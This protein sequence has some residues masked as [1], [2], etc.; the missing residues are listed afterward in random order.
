MCF[1][2]EASFTAAAVLGA[3]GLFTMSR[4]TVYLLLLASV[5]FFFALQQ[6]AEGIVWVAINNGWYPNE[7]SL[8]AQNI[9]LMFAVI[10]WPIWIPFALY[11]AE[12]VEWRRYLLAGF[13]AVGVLHAIYNIMIAQSSGEPFRATVVG[14]SLQDSGQVISPHAYLAEKLIYLMLIIIPCFISSLRSMWLF[15]ILVT[16]AYVGAEYIYR[17]NFASVWC[18]FAGLVSLFLY[19]V[20]M[21]NATEKKRHR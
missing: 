4:S 7:S 8:A 21:D 3:M 1:S 14:H 19:K 10:F 17:N 6:F 16:I 9:Y 2:A 12:R 20:I 11:Y 15:G 18:F 13:L 5:P